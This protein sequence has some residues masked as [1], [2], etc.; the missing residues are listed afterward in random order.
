M[1]DL[2]LATEY[3]NGV[4]DV[5]AFLAGPDATVQRNVHLP[6]LRSKRKRQVDVLI[7]T[8]VAGLGVTQVVVD[9]KRHGRA[10]DVPDVQSFY[11]FLEDVGVTGGVLIASSGYTGGAKE[12]AQQARGL[13]LEVLT[14]DELVT[15]QPPG[16][17]HFDYEVPKDLVRAATLKLRR[18]GFRVAPTN[19]YEDISGG[20]VVIRVFRHFGTTNPTGEAQAGAGAKVI[21]ALRAAGVDNPRNR[22]NGQVVQGGTPG[23]RWIMTTY[24]GEPLVKVLAAT[25]DEL[26][27]QL[28]DLAVGMLAH[29]PDAREHLAYLKPDD[30]PVTGLFAGWRHA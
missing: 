23:H 20:I 27:Q 10:I 19:E 1:S 7:T 9:C 17:V 24:R 13:K 30:W 6:G 29:L 21:D 18:A 25:E 5:L 22:A 4:A 26:R 8:T 14:I 11:G 28:D 12:F 3:E 2:G 16:T 15:W